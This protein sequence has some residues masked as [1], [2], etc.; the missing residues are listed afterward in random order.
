MKDYNLIFISVAL[1]ITCA[2]TK[3]N[4]NPIPTTNTNTNNPPSTKN[5]VSTFAGS[6]SNGFLNGNGIAAAFNFPTDVEIDEF[7]NV[8]VTDPANNVIRKI[9]VTGDVT[10]F[11][12]SGST[13]NQ[14]GQGVNASFNGPQGL[15]IDGDGNLIIA[16]TGNNLIR[17][18]SP[19]GQVT[20]IAGS[21]IF[22]DANGVGLLAE[23]SWPIDVV[24]DKNGNIYVGEGYLEDYNRIR[25]ITPSG[26]TTTFAGFGNGNGI[27]NNTNS[28][29]IFLLTIDKSE[30]IYAADAGNNLIYKITPAGFVS[31]FAGSGNSGLVNGIGSN[32][33]FNIPNGIGIDNN[34]NILVGDTGNNVI[35]KITPNG[36]VTTFAGSGM[37]GSDNGTMLKSTF[38]YPAGIAVNANGDVFV[39]D[40]GNSLIRKISQ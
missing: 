2:C 18:I 34:G 7:G 40:Y 3:P 11:A 8:F 16:D 19:S 27:G 1:A 13:G 5:Q 37:K 6:G 22:G 24:V 26:I 17:K 23:F 32:T 28:S 12:G 14:N 38:Y 10:T 20:T 39:A 36:V 35:R 31:T 33:S 25:K 21:G 29:G 9:S 15:T 30:N 4:N